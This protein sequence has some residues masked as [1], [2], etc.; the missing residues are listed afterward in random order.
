MTVISADASGMCVWL[1]CMCVT[2]TKRN[3]HPSVIASVFVSLVECGTNLA[4][5]LVFLKVLMRK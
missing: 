2:K 1:I 4:C 5:G 3:A